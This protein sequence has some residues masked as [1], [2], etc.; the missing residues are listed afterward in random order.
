MCYAIPGGS[1][2]GGEDV[3]AGVCQLLNS[4]KIGEERVE[5][6]CMRKT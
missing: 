6:N 1:I 5:R 3:P 4:D 2:G